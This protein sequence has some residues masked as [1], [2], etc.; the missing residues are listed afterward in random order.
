M[1]LNLTFSNRND[2]CLQSGV[3]LTHILPSF[4]AQ[5]YGSGAIQKSMELT[6]RVA[7]DPELDFHKENGVMSAERSTLDSLPP[8]LY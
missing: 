6:V 7:G 2:L 4:L 3:H 5:R 8:F 1:I